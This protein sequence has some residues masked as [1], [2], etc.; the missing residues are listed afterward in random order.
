MYSYTNV[1]IKISKNLCTYTDFSVEYSV[2][3]LLLLH[4]KYVKD[5]ST[6]F[7]DC[8]IF[9]TPMF[10]LSLPLKFKSNYIAHLILLLNH[11]KNN[12]SSSCSFKRFVYY[13]HI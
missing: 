7:R 5:T 4:R 12:F 8:T 9:K 11:E 13:F 10:S 1:T 2:S 3:Y 6:F